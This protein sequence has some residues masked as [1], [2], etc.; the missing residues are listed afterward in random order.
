MTRETC[1]F[2]CSPNNPLTIISPASQMVLM[3][4]NPPAR[5]YKRRGFYSWIG[6]IPWRRAWQPPPVFLPGKPQSQGT[7]QATV[8]R[9]AKS[10]TWLKWLSTHVHNLPIEHLAHIRYSIHICWKSVGELPLNERRWAETE[11]LS[12]QWLSFPVWCLQV[13]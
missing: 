2:Y 6:K 12:C 5:R 13:H 3:V 8:H 9:M 10:Q 4:K 7:W 11:D 1:R